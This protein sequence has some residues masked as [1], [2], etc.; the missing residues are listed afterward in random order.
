VDSLDGFH[1]CDSISER[2]EPDSIFQRRTARLPNVE[3]LLELDDETF[4]E[5]YELYHE[6][7]EP[8]RVKA[9]ARQVMRRDEFRDEMFDV[10]VTKYVVR[11]RGRAVG[12]STLTRDLSTVPWIEP[13]FYAAR[14]PEHH[15]RN[16]IFY[17]GITLVHP[18]HQG[19]KVFSALMSE[20]G[21]AIRAARGLAAFDICSHNESFKALHETAL[22]ASRRSLPSTLVHADRQTYYLIDMNHHASL[23]G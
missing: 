20:M 13:A 1:A 3:V 5:L 8:L 6:A 22:T 11:S 7:F 12:L 15:A 21:K 16:A 19:S 14:F 4:E 10:R 18:D 2:T 9:A 23:R 17:Q